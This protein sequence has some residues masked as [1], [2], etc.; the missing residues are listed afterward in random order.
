MI[1]IS[2]FPVFT[3]VASNGCD[4]TADVKVVVVGFVKLDDG[5]KCG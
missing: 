4:F 3:A 1:T 2:A 5:A